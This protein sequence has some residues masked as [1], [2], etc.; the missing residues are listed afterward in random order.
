[1]EGVGGEN[2]LS[3]FGC[4]KITSKN[5]WGK[6]VQIHTPQK[7]VWHWGK[8]QGGTAPILA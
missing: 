7:A 2:W 6:I 4:V 5:S 1:M 3:L 8:V